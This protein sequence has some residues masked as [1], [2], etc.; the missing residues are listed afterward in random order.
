MIDEL[1]KLTCLPNTAIKKWFEVKRH[2]M[3]Q[4]AATSSE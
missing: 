2:K 4:E 1:E 3:K